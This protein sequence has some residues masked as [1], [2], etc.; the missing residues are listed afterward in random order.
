MKKVSLF[1]VFAVVGM[2]ATPTSAMR[3]NVEGSVNVF[4]AM[5]LFGVRR[6]IHISSEE[7]YGAFRAATIQ[8]TLP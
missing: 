3:T 1:V 4:D 8:S 6:C 5:R 7:S 2:L